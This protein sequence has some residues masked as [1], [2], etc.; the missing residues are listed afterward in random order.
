MTAT[1]EEP[2]NTLVTAPT[3][4]PADA[5]FEEVVHCH[6][7]VTGLDSVIVVHSTAPHPV[8]HS[9]IFACGPIPTTTPLQRAQNDSLR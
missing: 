8:P 5:G 3:F 4:V 2:R 6:D 7:V 9:E 1:T